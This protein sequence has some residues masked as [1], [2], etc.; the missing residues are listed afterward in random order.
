M[1]GAVP[2]SLPLPAHYDHNSE[3]LVR[4]PGLTA[5]G[6]SDTKHVILAWT[7]SEPTVINTEQISN[8]ERGQS[9]MANISQ[10]ITKYN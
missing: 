8:T 4:Q 3:V 2:D 5:G 7:G 10:L 6:C 1:S 9:F